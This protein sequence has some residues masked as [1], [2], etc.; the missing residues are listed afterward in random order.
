MGFTPLEGVPMAT[1]SG[2]VDPGVLLY[3]QRAHGL[4]IDDVD[5]ALNVA[6]GLSGLSGGR[7]LPELAIAAEHDATAQL[8]FDVYA[9]R[10]ATAIAGMGAALGGVDAITFTAG[11]GENSPAVR[12]AVCSRL[13]FLGVE[14]DPALNE[15]STPDADVGMSASG[16][17]VLVIAA[18]EELVVARAVRTL[19]E[20]P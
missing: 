15:T 20:S 14:L 7:E 18:R 6:S 9:Y 4:S 12:A 16:V 11:V 1:R 13:G 8:A 3:V 10:I 17:R 5:E 19:L 2:S